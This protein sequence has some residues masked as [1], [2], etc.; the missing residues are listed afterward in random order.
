MTRAEFDWKVKTGVLPK[1]RKQAGFKELF[2]YKCDLEKYKKHADKQY[3]E[4]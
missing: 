3:S 1:G 2:Y 4:A